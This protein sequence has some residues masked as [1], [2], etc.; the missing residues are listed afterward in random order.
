MQRVILPLQQ[1]WLE[2]NLNDQD[3]VG[4]FQSFKLSSVDLG[5]LYAGDEVDNSLIPPWAKILG[6]S[7][8]KLIKS[9]DEEQFIYLWMKIY[10]FS[11]RI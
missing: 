11:E 6:I 1:R 8:Q 5:N 9:W 3:F 7:Q 4:F 2:L 10:R